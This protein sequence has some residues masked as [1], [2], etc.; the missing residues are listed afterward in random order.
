MRRKW[1]NEWMVPSFVVHSPKMLEWTCARWSARKKSPRYI[2]NL[3]SLQFE[4]LSGSET[5][6]KN[7]TN[8]SDCEHNITKQN[9]H[10]SFV[11]MCVY[12]FICQYFSLKDFCFCPPEGQE[13]LEPICK[14]HHKTLLVWISHHSKEFVLFNKW[15]NKKVIEI[16]Q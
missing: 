5:P 14:T 11:W 15:K 4:I 8:Q 7:E 13:F 16:N 9:Q 3:T 12:V 10:F 1:E 2:F 6:Q